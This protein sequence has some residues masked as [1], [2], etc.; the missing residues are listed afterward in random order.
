MNEAVEAGARSV[1]TSQTFRYRP[2]SRCVSRWATSGSFL[3]LITALCGFVLFNH[4][5]FSAATS[6][7]ALAV[8]GGDLLAVLAPSSGLTRAAS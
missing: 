8:L 1:R 3:A 4:A 7:S 5:A 6:G 2:G